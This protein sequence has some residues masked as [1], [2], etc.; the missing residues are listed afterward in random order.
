MSSTIEIVPPPAEGC[1]ETSRK[2]TFRGGT[3]IAEEVHDL[4]EHRR[5]MADADLYRP[6]SCEHCGQGPLHVHTRPERHPCKDPSLPPVVTILQ[7]RCAQCTATWRILPLFLARCLWHPWQVIERV[8][9]PEEARPAPS[10][11]QIA[12]RTAQ[13]WRSRVASS[14]RVL[15]ALLS[16]SGAMI[17]EQAATLVGLCGT[18]EA[19]VRAYREVAGSP[20]GEYLASVGAL[21]DRLERGIRLM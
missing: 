18:R 5:R 4:E 7:F 8:V 3:R 15:V 6:Q 21:V 12:P 16:L 14:A 17:L 1:L 10:A 2:S 11:P 9:M 20:R 19:L 13:R